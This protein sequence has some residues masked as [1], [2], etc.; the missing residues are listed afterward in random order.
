MRGLLALHER[1]DRGGACAQGLPR[2][3]CETRVGNKECQTGAVRLPKI[4]V[5]AGAASERR[6]GHCM[7][8]VPGT[9]DGRG[10]TFAR[11][12]DHERQL[13][14]VLHGDAEGSGAREAQREGAQ[15][16]ARTCNSHP[17]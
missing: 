3:P 11:L 16:Q 15:Q 9:L 7:R 14:L 13:R 17:Y 6:G 12:E 1:L 8:W 4:L 5:L 10:R 2:K